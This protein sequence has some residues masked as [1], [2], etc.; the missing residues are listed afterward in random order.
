MLFGLSVSPRCVWLP[1]PVSAAFS[2]VCSWGGVHP[3]WVAC[4]PCGS[5]EE[6]GL[7]P[8]LRVSEKQ[9]S[10]HHR[11]EDLGLPEPSPC[12]ITIYN[13]NFAYRAVPREK[14]NTWGAQEE[15]EHP[16]ATATL[17]LEVWSWEPRGE[18]CLLFSTT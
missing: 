10:Q 15:A 17:I 6:L 8:Q 14:K 13:G 11:G 7:T 3:H 2:V 1:L 4:P 5:N 12:K 9:L 18:K 16:R